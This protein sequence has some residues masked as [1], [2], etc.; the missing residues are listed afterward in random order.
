MLKTV[1]YKTA[2]WKYFSVMIRWDLE[3][4]EIKLSKFI[5]KKFGEEITQAQEE[6]LLDLWTI[7]GFVTPLKTSEIFSS[8]KFIWNFADL[9]L[10]TVKNFYAAA[11]KLAL[12]SKN[13]NIC[14]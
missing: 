7:R 14:D 8:D 6:D 10:K 9:S 4:N 1:V 11:N 12:S 13:V 5:R 2:E 3:I